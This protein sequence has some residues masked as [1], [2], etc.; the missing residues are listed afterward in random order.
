MSKYA[1]Y[2]VDSAHYDKTR[3]AVGVDLLLDCLAQTDVPLAK[4]SVLEAG[5][6]TGNY[7]AALLPHVGSLVGVDFSQGMLAQAR[8]KLGDAVE[9]TCA[10]VLELPF[11][12]E[13][14]DGVTCNQ[15]IHHLEG[16]PGP[17]DDPAQWPA[18]DCPGIARF[19]AEAWRVLRPGGALALNYTPPHQLFDG[20][21]WTDLIPEAAARQAYRMPE[22][23]RLQDLLVDARFTVDAVTPE[24][25]GIL[26]GPSY[27]D[28]EGPLKESWRRGDSIWTLA[29]E[30]ELARA[31]RRVERMLRDDAMSAYL[32]QRERRRIGVGQS[33][34]VCAR[35]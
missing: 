21:W 8:A 33:T 19:L 24:L 10:S 6:G 9:L 23:D 22:L 11:D 4:Q 31:V 20:H 18:S 35:K 26:Q 28:P 25:E 13:R 27:L 7:L 5:C 14:F 15:V 34:F 12:D 3:I 29:S 1:D 30:E 17:D 32:E 16:G 2:A